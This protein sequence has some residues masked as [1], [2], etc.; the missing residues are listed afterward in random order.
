MGEGVNCIRQI[1]S[2]P[3]PPIATLVAEPIYSLQV[4]RPHRRC[5]SRSLPQPLLLGPPL[6]EVA[7]HTG[8]KPCPP[9]I[10]FAA[11]LDEA[12]ERIQ[13]SG[14]IAIFLL[15]VRETREPSKVPPVGRATITAEF[16]RQ[17]PRGCRAHFLAEPCGMLY[18]SLVIIRRCF[19]DHCGTNARLLHRRNCLF[20][21][22]IDHVRSEEH[23]SELQSLR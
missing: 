20:G 7:L 3:R 14:S 1:D 6:F 13:A 12:N 5:R 16:L 11:R 2:S 19:D 15:P 22:I 23:T 17:S 21:Q 8:Q 18:P 4:F 10:K 9:G